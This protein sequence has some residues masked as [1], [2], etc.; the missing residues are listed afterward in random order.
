[1]SESVEALIVQ[2]MKAQ[3]LLN[4]QAK[5]VLDECSAAMRQSAAAKKN[6]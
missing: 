4:Q 1:V 5:K 2:E 3:Q 6:H